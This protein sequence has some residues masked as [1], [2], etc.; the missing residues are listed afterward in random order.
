[1]VGKKRPNDQSDEQSLALH[2]KRRRFQRLCEEGQAWMEELGQEDALVLNADRTDVL[3]DDLPVV[4]HNEPPIFR[5]NI[6]VESE[7]YG[8]GDDNDEEQVDGEEEKNK[9]PE[10]TPPI[11]MDRLI[12]SIEWLG[13][14]TRENA[15]RVL[16]YLKNKL[17]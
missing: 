16:Y 11:K 3:M 1:M 17:C 12:F 13:G 8:F 2:S 14:D 6:Y 10:T 4:I 7:L 15:N 5:A 9:K